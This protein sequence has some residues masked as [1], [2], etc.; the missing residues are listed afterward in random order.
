MIPAQHSEVAYVSY[1]LSYKLERI[2][3]SCVEKEIF[4]TFEA[5]VY[6]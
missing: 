4:K 3:Y 1:I 6:R 5:Q 2:A